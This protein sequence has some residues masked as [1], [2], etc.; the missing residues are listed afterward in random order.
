MVKINTEYLEAIETFSDRTTVVVG[1]TFMDGYQ[2]AE[3]RS[4][5]PE[6]TDAPILRT[7][8]PMTYALGGAGNVAANLASL[9]AN[10]HL[11]YIAG[12]DNW[13]DRIEKLATEA[14]I[15]IHPFFEPVRKQETIRKERFV[16]NGKYSTRIDHKEHDLKPMSKQLLGI[17][18]ED[19]GNHLGTLNPDAI[20]ASDYDKRV[21]RGQKFGVALSSLTRHRVPLIVD[22]KPVNARTF[23]GADLVRPNL[24]EAKAI[25]GFE[26]EEGPDT[27]ENYEKLLTELKRV[28]NTR[29]VVVTLSQHG[30]ACLDR[31]LGYMHLPAEYKGDEAQVIGCGDTVLATLAM[32]KTSGLDL[33]QAT[34]LANIAAGV[35]VNQQGTS[36]INLEGLVEAIHP[37]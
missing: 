28:T 31:E 14:G 23:Y 19:I 34:R 10:V 24:A 8:G 2:L 37:L 29:N 36:K 33:H 5:N 3:L 17:M 32:G 4:G 18:C 27:H 6:Q 11:F 7:I 20:V 25:T 16:V 21:F 13:Q 35:V 26:F 12:N 30:I 15:T 22:P 1:D 9:G